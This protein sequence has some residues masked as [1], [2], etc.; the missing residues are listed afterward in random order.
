MNL[1]RATVYSYKLQNNKET[2]VLNTSWKK[3]IATTTNVNVS[4]ERESEEKNLTKAK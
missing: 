1:F 2:E 4:F 3:K